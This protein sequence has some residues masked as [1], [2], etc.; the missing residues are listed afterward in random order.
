MEI[1]LGPDER[2]LQDEARA[3]FAALMT[4]ALREELATGDGGGPRHR[5]A[6]RSLGADGWLGLGWPVAAGGRGRP[7]IEQLIF[8]DE[9]ERAG[10]PMPLLTLNTVGPTL[11]RFGTAA[12]QAAYLPRILAG[13]LWFSIGYTEPE[14]GTDLASLRTRAVRDGDVYIV[15]GQ[16]VFTSLAGHADYIWLAARTAPEAPKHKGISILIV[17]ARAPGV[18]MTPTAV[19]GDNAVW[20]T[21]YEDV[22]VPVANRVGEEGQGWRLITT[23]LNHERV[24]LC[25][26]GMLRRTVEEVRAWAQ[27]TRTADGARVID[28]PWVQI[29]LARLHAR[30]EVLRL[31]NWRQA[32]SI[33]RGALP[34]AEASTVKVYGSELYVE[35]WRALAEILGPLGGLKR[36]SA[37]AVLEGRIERWARATQVLTFAAGANEVQRDLIATLG[38]G[39]PRTPY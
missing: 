2:A 23:Q 6:V 10:F 4:P 26:S 38:L 17:D 14:A 7:A 35:A 29:A 18:S 31:L 32:C 8:F 9:A 11:L 39:L 24:A 3:R 28:R 25:A 33:D 22:R 34:P 19:L 1:T 13:E 30:V 37:G 16:K 12:Q 36:G 21:Y 5:E 27:T 15:N 20:T